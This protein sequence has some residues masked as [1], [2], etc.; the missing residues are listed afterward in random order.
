MLDLVELVGQ[1]GMLCLVLLD[2][3]NQASRSSLPRRADAL[4]K[5]S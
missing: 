4:V 2:R 5:W 3:A 1:L